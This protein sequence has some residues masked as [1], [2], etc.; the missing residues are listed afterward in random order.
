MNRILI[1]GANR[2]LGLELVRLYAAR[3]DRVFAGCRTP[4]QDVELKDLS[5]RY[6]AQIDVLPLEIT[7]AASLDRCLRQVRSEV[8]AL[9]M[10]INN[11]AINAEGETLRTFDAQK[12]AQ[13]WM[14]N[15]VGQVLVA[16][17]FLDLLK[18]GTDPKIINITS[19]AGSIST[20]NRFRGYYYFGSKAAMNMFSR[21][22]A[23][24]P[25]TAGI[26]TI[27][28]HP[29]WVRTDM[30]G[31]NAHLSVTESA[32][33][34]LKVIANLTPDDNG[35]FYTWEGKEYPW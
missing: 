35:K 3:G 24:D 12:A 29:G 31:L 1:T 30:G 15:A 11:A 14:V 18:A 32:E 5:A 21:S 25:D 9:D 26:M 10:L 34:I 16:Q 33:G 23:W 6:P 19:E 4:E 20:M 17:K 2:G 27:A 7:E 22:M 8:D 28:L 13:Q